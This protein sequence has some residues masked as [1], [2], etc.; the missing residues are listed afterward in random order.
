VAVPDLGTASS[1][2]A[3]TGRTG[4]APAALQVKVDIK[5]TYS[6]DLVVDLVAPDGTVYNLQN[7]TGGSAANVT[8]TFTVNASSE[9]ANGTW[10]LRVSD[11]AAQ[12]TGKI[13]LWGLQF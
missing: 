7:R 5:H 10:S 8:K 2:I 13:D 9:A 12:D 11:K 1:T 3:V 6:G 4:N